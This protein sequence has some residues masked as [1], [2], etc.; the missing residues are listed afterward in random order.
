MNRKKRIIFPVVA[1]LL[2]VLAIYIMTITFNKE[3]EGASMIDKENTETPTFQ[4]VSVH[5]PSIIKEGD[6]YYVFGTHIEAGKSKDLMN[7]ERFTNGYQATDNALYGDLEMNLKES[8]KWAGKDDADSKGGYAVWAP[9]IFW[10]D[11]Y[12][13]EDGTKGAYMIYYSASSTYIRSAIGY[14]VSQDIEGPY[15]YVDTI[16]YSGFTEDDAFD[17]NSDVNKKWT[18]TNISELIEQGKVDGKNDDWF[19]NDGSYN[20]E[21]YPNA[22]DANLFYDQ[23]GDLW[24]VYGS[25]S[26]GIYLLEINKETGQAIYPG[27]DGVTE[28]GR[29][30]DRYFGTHISG[31]F[32]KSGEGPYVVYDEDRGFYYLYVTYGWLGADGE[33][34]MRIFRSENPTGPYTDADGKPAVLPNNTDNAPYGNKMMGHFLFER[35]VGDPTM[36]SG[37][38]YVSPGHNSVLTDDNDKQ[39]VV[40]HTRFPD[41][42]E[43]FE[44]RVHP[45]YY[46]SE[47]WPVFAPYRYTGETL[48]KIDE[49]SI[50]GEYKYLNHEKDNNT[51]VKRSSYILLNEDKTISGEIDGIWRLY[52]DY[53]IEIKT[54]NLTYDG[55]LVHQWDHTSNQYVLTFTALSNKGVSM[56]GSKLVDMPDGEVVQAVKQDLEIGRLDQINRDLQLPTVGFHNSQIDWESSNEKIV[57]SSGKV[58]QQDDDVQVTL[59]VNITKGDA[60]ATKSFDLTVIAKESTDTIEKLQFSFED[61]LKEQDNL[62]GEGIITGNR[63]NNSGGEITFADGIKGKAAY[64]N[65]YSGIRLPNGLIQSNAYTVTLWVKPES[66]ATHTT[67]FF[68]AKDENNWISL[69]LKGTVD[70]QTMIWSGSSEWYDAPTGTTI[71]VNEWSHLGFVVDNEDISVYLNGKQV[72]SG[73]QFPSI[74]NPTSSFGLGVNYWDPP[75]QGLI[76]ELIIFNRAISEEEMIQLAKKD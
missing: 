49:K 53:R 22:I 48:S 75:Y 14:A 59:T 72:F 34:N 20:N 26:G 11:D 73:S 71:P 76:D 68:G 32:A 38:G 29:L 66:L 23:D 46:N 18:N 43:M 52:D 56:W 60:Q 65:G 69:V 74:F 33:Y 31:G 30:I 51:T 27:E 44:T 12:V 5:D 9:D 7:W 50:P 39:F 2:I 21:R 16:M 35:H 28:D 36:G 58:N 40:F 1:I 25:W 45:I 17:E 64:F 55:V 54:N 63:L 3:R 13:N 61:N 19:R 67:T 4:N 62:V 15:Q 10:N 42:G 57:S 41:T 6:T 47:D 37:Y 24:M 70:D 8:F